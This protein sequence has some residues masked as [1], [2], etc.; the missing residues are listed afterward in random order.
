[1][2]KDI[3]EIESWKGFKEI[4]VFDVIKEDE[5][6]TSLY[7]KNY[8]G[9]KLPK[10]IA[11]QFI[12]VRMKNE[13]GSFTVPRQYTLSLNSNGEFYRIS[14]KREEEGLLSKKLCDEVK[15]G[16][17]LYITAPVGKFLLT[18]NERPLN[19]L[20]GGIGITPMLTMAYEAVKTNRKI[21]LIYSIPNSQNHSFEEEIK[22][23]DREHE[24]LKVTIFYTRPLE[25]DKLGDGFHV[26]GRISKEYIE[27]NLPI[28]GDFYFCG[29]L[30]FMK[31]LYDNL[32]NIGVNKENINYELFGPGEDIAK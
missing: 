31:A 29:P 15:I 30:A 26:K 27:E 7:L 4:K 5:F 10:F 32:V 20:G 11:G 9:S 21:N 16:D 17:T 23:L 24:N 6:V 8:D 18:D 28:D 13:D 14:I 3:K 25:S 12:A 2:L 22:K 1:M 19:L